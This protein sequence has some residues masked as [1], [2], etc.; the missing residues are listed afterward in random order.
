[1]FI[2]GTLRPGLSLDQLFTADLTTTVVHGTKLL[3]NYVNPITHSL[4]QYKLFTSI[5]RHSCGDNRSTI[6]KMYLQKQ[7]QQKRLKQVNRFKGT[8]YPYWIKRDT[9]GTLALAS[10]HTYMT[11]LQ[12]YAKNRSGEGRTSGHGSA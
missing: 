8:Y 7:Q 9:A 3:I 6:I 1:M 11:L 2:C 12:Y 5:F 4:T 10:K